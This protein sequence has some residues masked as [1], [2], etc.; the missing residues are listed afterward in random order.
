MPPSSARA[1]SRRLRSL[2][3]AER[4]AFVADLWAARGYET[5]VEGSVVVAERGID[6]SR[7]RIA[8]APSVT[9]EAVDAVFGP[10][11][12]AAGL[13]DD[14]SVLD[15]EALRGMLLYAVDRD[16][17]EELVE[18]HLGRSLVEASGTSPLRDRLDPGASRGPV[19][20]AVAALLVVVV[21]IGA[22]GG[23]LPLS[24]VGP[25]VEP[26]PV[27]PDSPA[28]TTP[29]GTTP[30]PLVVTVEDPPQGGGDLFRYPPGLGTSGVTNAS[31]LA[32]AH[33]STLA[34]TA[35]ELR[36]HHNRSHDLV[37]PFR[38]W[39]TAEQ[40]VVRATATRYRFEVTGEASLENGSVATVSYVDY[41]DGAA[42]YRRLIGLHGSAFERTRLPTS[43]GPG[44]FAAVSAA[45]VRRSLTTT[46]TRVEPV[47]V[48]N[49]TRTRVV[50]TGTP[51]AMARTVANYS[52]VAVVDRRG[53]V[54]SLTVE[55]TLLERAPDPTPNGI[56]TPY[57]SPEDA[58]TEPVGA[59]RFTMRFAPIEAASLTAPSWYGAAR[60]ATNG[61]ELQ[62]WPNDPAV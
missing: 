17:A 49:T 43:D 3:P 13:G 46:E 6:G 28:T 18:G 57:A 51:T 42:N 30:N 8:C 24:D 47:R 16:T 20:A 35:W 27:P 59:V 53:V 33:R 14:V 21:V 26:A 58:P 52:A 56:A 62:P 15:A 23:P 34:A 9:Y 41:G 50:A 60:N 5:T 61:T 48:D 31:A 37:H 32:E 11:G 54:R 39:H 4:A 19:M 29:E 7:Q 25:S 36:L 55:Y 40:S 44:V 12:S 22:A 1:L 10:E 45:Y 2:D 38:R